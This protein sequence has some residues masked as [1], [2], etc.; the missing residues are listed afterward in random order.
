MLFNED[1]SYIRLSPAY[2]L[3]CTSVYIKD[4][5]PALTINGKHKWLNKQ[6]II[7]FG[8]NVCLLSKEKTEELIDECIDAIESTIKELQEYIKENKEF[9]DI[10]SRMIEI[11]DNTLLEFENKKMVRITKSKGFNNGCGFN[12]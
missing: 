3:V 7:E 9:M 8:K 5:K 2:D 12:R 1:F 6:E 11:W 4:D 10:G